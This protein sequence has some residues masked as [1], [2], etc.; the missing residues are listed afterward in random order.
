[1]GYPIE[2]PVTRKTQ[3]K[4]ILNQVEFKKWSLRCLKT[5]LIDMLKNLIING[6]NVLLRLSIT[7]KKGVLDSPL[8][9]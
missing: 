5:K 2:I 6:T 3:S 9:L 4:S 1:M 7:Y 8:I